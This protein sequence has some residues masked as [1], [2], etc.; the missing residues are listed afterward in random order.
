MAEPIRSV[1][2]RL[3]QRW[4][5]SPMLRSILTLVGG[6]GFA[7]AVAI[8][9]APILSRLYEPADFG[10][11]A[12]VSSSA[13]LLT[14]LATARYELAV[15]LPAADAEARQLI[16]LAA[17]L[18]GVSSM[19]IALACWL[20]G[21]HLFGV[22]QAAEAAH[23]WWAVPVTVLGAGLYQVGYHWALRRKAYRVLAGTRIWQSLSGTAI[24]VLL[25]WWL[26]G[27]TGLIIGLVVSQT[28]GVI[29]FARLFR[30]DRPTGPDER[31]A[32]GAPS[33]RW[34]ARAHGRFAGLGALA[35]FLNASGTLLPPL[36]I[37]GLYGKGAAGSFAFALRLISLP[38]QFVGT[39]VSQV[40]LA[41]AATLMRDR[42]AA[43]P[44]LLFSLT[45]RLLRLGV[46]IAA[47]GWL[48]PLAFPWLFGEAWT[49]AGWAAAWIAL[50]AAAQIVVSPVSNVAILMK[51]QD[52]QL[53][54][55][56]LR[57]VA[58]VL[59]LGIP[60]GLG[61]GFLTATAVFSLAM[62]SVFVV[63]FAAYASLA[64]RLEQQTSTPSD[65]ASQ[66]GLPPR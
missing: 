12:V 60:A 31:A 22:F 5:G 28:A 59:A 66:G 61:A 47:A 29:R 52:V 30:A 63:S 57:A 24:S 6:T 1:F 9:A 46:L 41:E 20:W 38:M 19:A 16:R 44:A 39:A 53:A 32:S 50:Y 56:V 4:G 51:R 37:A 36:L 64:R 49:S 33:L 15:P 43:V 65:G 55:D 42:P 10:V 58:V 34:T 2:G 26:A 21:S 17:L 23:F 45:R 7:Q 54:L 40:F 35:G 62:F 25:G 14:F 18:G 13:G 8:L 11:L 27:P 3:R 48:S